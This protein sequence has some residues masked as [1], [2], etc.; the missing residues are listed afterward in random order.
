LVKKDTG[1]PWAVLDEHGDWIDFNMAGHG[2][3]CRV[4]IDENS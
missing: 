3:K 2:N 4:K 1:V